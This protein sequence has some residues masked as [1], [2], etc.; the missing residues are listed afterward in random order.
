MNILSI[1][2]SKWCNKFNIIDESQ[3]G[4]RRGYSTIDNVF[5]LMALVQKH[6]SKKRRKRVDFTVYLLIMPKH[7]LV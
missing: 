6:I 7:L 5:T 3:A 4:F 1:Q 2:L